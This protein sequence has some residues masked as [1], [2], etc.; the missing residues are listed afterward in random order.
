LF[1]VL[2]IAGVSLLIQNKSFEDRKIK[3]NQPSIY[4]SFFIGSLLGLV[5]GVVGIGGGI[6]LSPI[7]FLL[8]AAP[9]KQI[10]TTASFFILI[11]SISGVLGQLTKDIVYDQIFNYWILFLAV[12]IGGQIGNF[13]NLKIFSNRS[14][15]LVTACLVIFVAIRMGF[16]II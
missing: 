11:N 14:L 3:Y 8:K 16:K 13:I 15:A 12:F 6:F 4:L 1:L 7:L 2:S 10:V 9:P 5:S